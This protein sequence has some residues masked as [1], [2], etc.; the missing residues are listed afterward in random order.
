MGEAGRQRCEAAGVSWFDLSG[1][2]RIVGPGLRIIVQGQPNR[3]ARRGRPAS[4]FAPK[5][6]R[7]ARQLLMNVTSLVA[8]ELVEAACRYVSR[9][10]ARLEDQLVV[11]NEDGTLRARCPPLLDAWAEAYCFEKHHITVTLPPVPAM[12]LREI[13]GSPEAG[14]ARATGLGAAWLLTHFAGFR[15]ASFYL[16]TDPSA[17]LLD[18]IGFREEER[19]ANVWLI[20]P[21]DEGVF[22]GAAAA[23]AV[24]CVHPVQVFLDL[25][26]HPER[27][28]EAAAEQRKRFLMR[29]SNV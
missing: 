28:S 10:V 25:G 3:F 8:A 19:G 21:D 13:A 12:T 2:A 4:V 26:A 27:A 17:A 9:I 16:Q 14:G 15:L 1:N 11:R 6:A 24:V 5:S 29:S 20:V 7:I 18:Q 22:Q 23:D